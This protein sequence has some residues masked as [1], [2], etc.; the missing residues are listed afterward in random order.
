MKKLLLL[1][2]PVLLLF[3]SWSFFKGGADMEKE[4]EEVLNTV[5]AHYKSWT[6]LEDL[7]EQSKYIQDDI[8]MI[9]PGEKDPIIGKEA[10]LKGY[11]KWNNAAEVHFFKELNPIVKLSK[12]MSSA[13]VFYNIDMAFNYNGEEKTFQGRDLFFLTKEDGKWLIMANEYSRHPEKEGE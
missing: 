10:Y 9:T 7:S 1:I 11:E 3:C 13:V 5:L 8:I 2:M 6:V 4:K 12:N